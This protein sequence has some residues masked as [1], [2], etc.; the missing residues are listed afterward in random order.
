MFHA[1]LRGRVCGRELIRLLRFQVKFT[2]AQFEERLDQILN[3]FP[4]MD[5][6]SFCVEMCA[7]DRS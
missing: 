5:V 7:G 1:T 3:D 6:S 2:Q 4:I